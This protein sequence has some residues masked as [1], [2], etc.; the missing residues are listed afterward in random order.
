MWRFVNYI[1][2]ELPDVKLDENELSRSIQQLQQ[3]I[4]S[5]KMVI[6]KN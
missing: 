5:L 4:H 3:E 2:P 6:E 1:S